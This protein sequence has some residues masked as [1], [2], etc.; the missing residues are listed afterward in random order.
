MN[1][2]N[3]V[4]MSQKCLAVRKISCNFATLLGAEC[5]LGEANYLI[6][7]GIDGESMCVKRKKI[8]Y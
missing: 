4:K 7:S 1:W 3:N 8:K 6:V 5:R 2:V